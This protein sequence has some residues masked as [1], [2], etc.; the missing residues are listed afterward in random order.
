MPFGAVQRKQKRVD[1]LCSGVILHKC[2]EIRIIT[3][4]VKI[5]YKA[6]HLPK[7]L[8]LLEILPQIQRMGLNLTQGCHE[9]LLWNDETGAIWTICAKTSSWREAMLRCEMVV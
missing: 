4:D 9:V 1:W 5:P 8:E 3:V 7:V 2:K 6:T